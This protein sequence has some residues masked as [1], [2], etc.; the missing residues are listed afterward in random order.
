MCI[1]RSCNQ[2]A[3][4]QQYL[5]RTGIGLR[6]SWFTNF[7]AT[8]TSAISAPCALKPPAVPEEMSRSGLKVSSA[9]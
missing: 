3:G 8:K 2:A 7:S 5:G 9:R 6:L 4:Q 1:T